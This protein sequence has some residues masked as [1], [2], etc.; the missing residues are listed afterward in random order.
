MD[1]KLE[2]EFILNGS[3]SEPVVLSEKNIQQKNASHLQQGAKAL[4]FYSSYSQNP[5]GILFGEQE[6]NE[7]ILLL[8]RRHFVTNVPWITL[9][10]ILIFLP[11]LFPFLIHYFPFPL[12]SQHTLALYL[13]FYYLIVFGFALINFTL[14]YFQ[15]GLVTNMRVIDVDLSGILYRQVA[16]A[17]LEHIEDVSYQQAGFIRSLFNYGTVLVQTAGTQESIEYDRVP[18]PSRVAEIIG[19]LSHGI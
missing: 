19:D 5:M 12:P 6:E 11:F 15:A 1:G 17:K 16:E 18:R 10:T 8:L 3:T 13:A 9:T 14:W 7:K 2:G 4:H